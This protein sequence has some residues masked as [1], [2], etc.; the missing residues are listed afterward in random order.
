MHGIYNG[1]ILPFEDI[2][3]APNDLGI[4]RGYAVFDFFRVN[5]KPVFIED[6]LARLERS[7]NAI[8]LPFPWAQE[9]LTKWVHQ[10]VE[11]NNEPQS[12]IKIIVTGGNS[13][14]GFQCVSPNI[15]ITQQKAKSLD[16]R[17]YRDGEKLITHEYL[18]DFS[19]AKTTNYNTA[20]SLQKLQKE[21]GA[22]DILYHHQ[23]NVLES[24]RSNFF[25][26]KNDVLH[27][28]GENVLLGITRSKVL[29]IAKG[30]IP[31]EIRDIA[32]EEIYQAD[33]AFITSTL[34][35]VLPITRIDDK[36]IT[37]GKPGNI[38]QSMMKAFEEYELNY[39]NT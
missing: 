2:K 32:L 18:R 24:T 21:S 31:V 30:Q 29:D 19:E 9:E 39:L 22:V 17:S 34:K 35:K 11:F 23:G 10:L 28:A 15:I 26:V 7:A 37:D 14:D 25:I 4:A 20:L 38:T 27:T 12:S 6:H 13:P 33:E 3:I 36:T 5:Q 1:D 16:S 8:N